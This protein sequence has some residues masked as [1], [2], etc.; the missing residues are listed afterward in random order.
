MSIV[1][2]QL[3]PLMVSQWQN[4]PRL[5]ALLEGYLALFKAEL[6]D[7]L[8]HLERQMSLDTAEGVWL[9]YI[10]ERLG[11]PRPGKRVDLTI[12]QQYFGFGSGTT[13]TSFDDA[14][15]FSNLGRAMEALEPVVDNWYRS[16]LRGRGLSLRLGTSVTEFEQILAVVFTG[17]GYIEESIGGVTANVSESREGYVDV[18]RRI[19]LLPSTAGI[20][21]TITE[22]QGG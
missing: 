15:Y 22:I 7:Q 4:A 5:R 18:V 20:T 10:G 9:D 19:G 14:P 1:R 16:M 2:R 13:R 21:L 8:D 12:P 3:T 11:L 6:I 17:G